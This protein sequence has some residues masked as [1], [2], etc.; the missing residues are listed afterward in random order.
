MNVAHLWDKSAIWF[1]LARGFPNS[2]TFMDVSRVTNLNWVQLAGPHLYCFTGQV[3]CMYDM[4]RRKQ[5]FWFIESNHLLFIN[6][7]LSLLHR[8]TNYSQSGGFGKPDCNTVKR[9]QLNQT[10]T[11][12]RETHTLLKETSWSRLQYFREEKQTNT[13]HR[14]QWNWWRLHFAESSSSCCQTLI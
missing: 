4:M 2:I 7:A 12:W 5:T 6:S 13:A 11:L 9:N 10:V 3:V 14:N 1:W 8:C